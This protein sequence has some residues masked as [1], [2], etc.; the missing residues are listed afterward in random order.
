M[1]NASKPKIT[2]RM[3]LKVSATMAAVVGVSDMLRGKMVPSFVESAQA[4][5]QEVIKY[6][7][8]AFC[9]QGDCQTVVKMVNGVVVKVEGDPNSPI[10]QG[11]LCGRGNAAIMNLYN[12][13][14]VKTPLKRTN[15]EKGVDVDPR[16]VEISWDEALNTTAEK[17]KACKAK[18]PRGLV[19]N[20]SFGSK[21][22]KVRTAF[23]QASGTPNMVGS[24]GPTCSVHYAS[25][26]VQGGGP[27]STPDLTYTDYH[28]TQGRTCGPNFAVPPASRRL[29]AA[30]ERGM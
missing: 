18:D 7:N 3:F 22:T 4:A 14:R 10:S 13:Y 15:P 20:E 30:L 16:W 24:H 17:L 28:I 5:D 6:G 9:Q 25:N 23:Q 8:C 11:M 21:E 12:A 1:E 2:R 26:I 19:V 27:V 29:T